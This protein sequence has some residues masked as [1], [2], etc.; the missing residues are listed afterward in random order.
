MTATTKGVYRGRSNATGGP[1]VW[2]SYNNG[3][4][5]AYVMDLEVNKNSLRFGRTGAEASL[6]LCNTDAQDVNGDG[7]LDQV[8]HFYTSLTGFQVSD[9]VGFLKG[10]TVEGIPIEGRD[11]VRILDH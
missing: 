7:L 9:T 4:P 5:S 2:E 3:M 1:W 10:L 8:C 6:A 11:A